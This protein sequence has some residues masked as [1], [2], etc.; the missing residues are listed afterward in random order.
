ML[1]GVPHEVPD[2]QEITGEAHLLY[3][4]D[5]A[6]EASLIIS[7]GVSQFAT[8]WLPLPDSLPPSLE[9]FPDHFLK[10]VVSRSPFTCGY[11]IVRK[12]IYVF[13]EL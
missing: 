6:G 7:H 11:R 8:T 4:R 1:L 13:R 5:L 10:V 12:V 9:P 2:D 3:H